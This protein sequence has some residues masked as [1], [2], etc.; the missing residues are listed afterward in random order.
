[1]LYEKIIDATTGEETLRPFT[2]D[3][4]AEYEANAAKIAEEVAQREA[5]EAARLAEKE[6]IAAA[7]GLT[8]DE[9][10]ALLG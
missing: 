5:D 8:I 2:A 9:L 10:K 3:E 4:I 6:R 7:L 1:M